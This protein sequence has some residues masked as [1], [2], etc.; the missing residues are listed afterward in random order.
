MIRASAITG[1]VYARDHKAGEKPL[2]RHQEIYFKLA[3]AHLF[4]DTAQML[5]YRCVWMMIEGNYDE[6]RVLA[7]CAKAFASESAVQ[8][9]GWALQIT[10]RDGYSLGSPAERQYRDAKLVEILGDPTEQHRMFIADQVL[11]EY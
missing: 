10:G 7:S 2:A 9:A 3:D 11:A 1:G 4:M 8:A 5:I 6:A